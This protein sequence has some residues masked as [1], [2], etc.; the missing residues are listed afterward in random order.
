MYPNIL[1]PDI[2]PVQPTFA[3]PSDNRVIDFPIRASVHDQMK[4]RCINQRNVVETE[5]R[6]LK[7]AQDC[8]A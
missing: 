6:H 2:D 5:V 8:L 3:L 1:S 4:L 7:V